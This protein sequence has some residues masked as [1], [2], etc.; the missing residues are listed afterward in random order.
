MKW[1]WIIT[2]EI[3]GIMAFEE[4]VPLGQICNASP[5]VQSPEQCPAL[6]QWYYTSRLQYC[7]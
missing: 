4:E 7:S 1:L 5:R 6:S 3:K 2:Y